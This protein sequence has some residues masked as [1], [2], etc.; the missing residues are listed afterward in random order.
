MNQSSRAPSSALRFYQPD[1]EDRVLLP[2]CIGAPHGP[3]PDRPFFEESEKVLV[4]RD[5]QDLYKRQPAWFHPRRIWPEHP[6][7]E[8]PFEAKTTAEIKSAY[9][10]IPRPPDIAE[11]EWDLHVKHV[12]GFLIT[13]NKEEWADADGL[14]AMLRIVI[15]GLDQIIAIGHFEMKIDVPEQ[16]DK[17]SEMLLPDGFGGLTPAISTFK[18]HTQG[19]RLY[20]NFVHMNEH[21]TSIIWD[22]RYGQLYY[23]DSLEQGRAS[24]IK[25]I[26][27]AWKRF[28]REAGY[29]EPF[30]L[31]VVPYTKQ[32]SSNE[33]GYLALFGLLTTLRGLVGCQIAGHTSNW[34]N[35]M[36]VS[37]N[38]SELT[39]PFHQPFDLRIR[40]W[41]LYTPEKSSI[42]QYMRDVYSTLEAIAG[43]ELGIACSGKQCPGLQY[44]HRWSLK[45]LTGLLEKNGQWKNP[46]SNED[47]HT[48]LGGWS[49]LVRDST[50]N[51]LYPRGMRVFQLEDSSDQKAP[52]DSTWEDPYR[53]LVRSPTT[54]ILEERPV[55]ILF[56]VS[57]AYEKRDEYEGL[58]DQRNLSRLGA[59]GDE[60]TRQVARKHLDNVSRNV[61]YSS[62]SES[63]CSL[64]PPGLMDERVWDR[65]RS[66]AEQAANPPRTGSTRAERAAARDARRG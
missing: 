56:R 35:G 33:C 22:K 42:K 14:H 66:E 34:Q 48:W 30:D 36:K 12:H 53:R 11:D 25:M 18:A 5:L 10:G 1:G 45:N 9:A 51:P 64:M 65:A 38:C 43:N 21:W 16:E 54:E 41:C 6:R 32:P 13:S 19:K 39:T 23:F 31:C 27:L 3:E 58:A 17:A 40:D 52:M 2:Y 29:P 28:L 61:V 20:A 7:K 50:L 8:V 55:P 37:F 4:D 46:P 26:R 62:Y 57:G 49:P 15:R 60:M 24:R 47:N 59:A 63:Y 44:R